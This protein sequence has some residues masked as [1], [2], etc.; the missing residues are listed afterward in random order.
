MRYL[1]AAT[2]M[3]S[4]GTAHADDVCRPIAGI[5]EKAEK[6][7]TWTVVSPNE[8]EFLRGISA[9]APNT[10]AGL[11]F[12]DSAAVIRQTGNDDGVILFIDGD[13]ACAPM[14]VPKVLLD[15][16]ATVAAGKILHQGAPL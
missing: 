13:Q 15:Q 11:P 4:I 3:L 8:W 14:P 1:I 9:M 7:G 5:K 16:L 12:G 10:P 2:L 6:K